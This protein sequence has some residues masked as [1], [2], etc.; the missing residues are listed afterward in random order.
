MSHS[1]KWISVATAALLGAYGCL[2]V[3]G[4]ATSGNIIG[5][6]TDPAGAVVPRVKITITSRDQGVTYST[7]SNESGN[8]S[9]LQLL[10]GPYTV[11][12]VAAGFQRYLQK[13]V[14]VNVDQSTR[15]DAQ[16]TVGQVSEEISVTGATP[17]LVTDRAEVSTTLATAQVND[18]PTLNRNFTNL[19]LL[20]PGAQK[21]SWQH[22][23]SENPQQ[24]IQIN[25]NGQ[26]FGSQNFMIDGA[27]NND[28]VLGIIVINPTIDSVSEFKYTTGNYDAEFAQ[29]GGAVSQVETKS[30]TNS[31]HGSLFE[32]LRNNVL[33]ARNPFSEPNGPPPLRWNQFG[34]SFGGP[35]KKNKL[36]FFGDYQ[37]SRQITGGS[38]VTTTPTAAMRAGDFSAFGVPIFDP[39]TGNADGSGRVQFPNNQIPSSRISPAAA[40]LL[41]LLPMPNSGSGFNNN[42]VASGSEAFNSDQFDVKVDDYLTDSFRF[43][44]RYS[45]AKYDK[46]SP[47]AFGPVAGG[48]DF[49]QIGFSGTSNVL[50]QNITGGFNDVLSP[51]LMTDFRFGYVRYRVNVRATDYGKNEGESVGIPGVNFPDRVDTSGLPEFNING[52][53]GFNEGFGLSINQCNCP[54]QEREWRLQFVDNWTKVHGNHTI[55]WG[56]DIGRAQNLRAPSDGTRNGYFQFSPDLTASA[57]V[58]GSGLGPASFLLGLPSSFSRFWQTVTEFP[59]DYQ[60]RM[61]YFVQDTWRVTQKLTLSYGLRWDTWFSN[62]SNLVGGG[63][64]YNVVTNMFEVAGVGLN[65]SSANVKTQL[66]NLS[67]R[68]AIA[69]AWNPKTVIR[70]GW[71]RSY[72]EEI[73]GANFNN[74]AYNY[75]TVISQS[76]PQ[77]NPFTPLFLLD[78]GPPAPVTPT[79]PGNGLLPLPPDVSA[80]YIPRNLKYP[81]VDSWNFSVERL[82]ADDLTAT[83]SYVGNVGRHLQ[84]GVPLNQAVPG[85]GPFDPRRPLYQEFGINNSVNDASNAGS[86]NYNALQLKLTKR[87]SHGL[88]LLATY[89]WS[90]ALGDAGGLGPALGEAITYGPL[91]WDRRQAFTLGHVWQLPFG[92]GRPFLSDIHGVAKQLLAGWEFSGITQYETGW[93]FSPTLN[94]NASINADVST[95]PDVVPSVNPYDVPGGQSRNLWFNPAAYTIPAPYKYGNA[96]Q[97]SLRGPNLF[98]AD[99][100]LSKRFA[101]RENMALQFRWENYNIF[102]YTNLNNPNGAVDAGPGSAGVITGLSSPMRQTQVGLRL[103]F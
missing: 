60:W 14:T 30:G 34:G 81:N 72:F 89:T 27:D 62:K 55:K 39:T 40:S 38:E 19:E 20:M 43:F 50:N 80:S 28:P 16:L 61:Y 76:L 82:I 48:T 75:P 47:A 58:A 13:D 37:G 78:N 66:G 8:Y 95:P 33:N 15:V 22:A 73:F 23:T 35:I 41:A 7:T 51:T 88:S 65:S 11:E 94:N 29:A 84:W 54:L 46:N 90:H 56:T 18:L 42:Y 64:D 3:Y 24:G 26:R 32:F 59:E 100:S 10:P 86:N 17:A 96:A 44:G 87:F 71:G 68:F 45:Y 52:N 85:P 77:V 49:P 83:V 67:P 92:P 97:G 53:G 12:F 2:G 70:T 102:N 98:T 91:A 79:I 63:S 36:F 99:W 4:Q 69:Y 93:P 101:L 57:D 1:H 9:Q 6:V 25:V 5:T 74:I 21:M 103:E 31:Y